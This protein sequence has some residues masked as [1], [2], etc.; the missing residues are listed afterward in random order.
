M[1]NNNIEVI[2]IDHGWANMKS[3]N[4]IFVSGIKE[5]TT[6][7]ALYD[8]VL[9]YKGKYYKIGGKRLE[10]KKTKVEDENYYLLTLAAVAKELERKGLRSANV[11]LA[12]GLPLTRFG[13]EKQDFIDYLS[14]NRQVTFRFEKRTYNI[15]I[16]RVSVFPQCYAAVTE[17]ISDYIRKRVVVDIGSWTIDIMPIEDK[18]PDESRCRT[19]NEGLL[20]CMRTIKDECIRQLNG[21]I[22]ESDIKQVM[23]YGKSDIDSRYYAIIENEIKRFVTEITN[24]LIEYGYNLETTPITFVGGGATVMKLFGNLKQS[25][26]QYIEDVKANAKG[27][28][29]LAKVFLNSRRKAR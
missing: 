11:F 20:T 26:I 10:V 15:T 29:Y 12:V 18:S 4:E 24:K 7:P 19:V 25:N 27:Y 28:E 22:E 9:E 2:G 6:E 16:F 23:M 21:A 17:Q 8:N 3:S 1:E 13:A 14:K 5:I